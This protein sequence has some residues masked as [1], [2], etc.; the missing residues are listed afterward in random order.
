MSTRLSNWPTAFRCASLA[1]ACLLGTTL[2]VPIM[3]ANEPKPDAE[4]G[5]KAEF[6]PTKLWSIHLEIPAAE[7]AVMLPAPGV[8]FGGG[9][10][11]PPKPQSEKKDDKKRATEK[12][13][14]GTE[15]PW[16]EA[17]IAIDG[18]A[19][20]QVGVRYT[21]DM[22]Y[23]V[24]GGGLKRPL[25]IG[26]DTFG[27]EPFRGLSGV[28]LQAMPLDPSRARQVVASGVFRAAGVPTPR[29]AFAEVTLTVPGKHDKEYLGLFTVVEDVDAR[30]LTDN[31]DS[32]SGLLMRPFGGRGLDDLG[33]D[34]ER[35]KG[36]YR[37]QRDVTKNEAKRVIEFVHLV[38]KS[39]DDEFKNRIGEFLNV[40]PFLRFMA[41]NALTANLES[42]FALGHNYVLYLDPKT[43][44]FHFIPGDLEFSFANFLLMGTPDQL[45]EL[46]VLKPYPGANKLPDRLLAIKEVNER[47]RQLLQELTEKAFTKE[48]LVRD[49]E[50]IEK[51]TKDI[52]AK[53]AT[54]VAA[55]QEQPGFGGAGLGPQ[56][57]D[58]KMFADKRTASVATQLSG[59]S[60]GYAPQQ[61]GFGPPPPGGGFGNSGGLGP[62]QDVKAIDERAFAVEVKAPAGF[63]ATL[64]AG[65]PKVNSPVAIACESSGAIYVA[66]DEQGSLGRTPG[67][68]RIV[69][70]V[71]RDSDGKADAATTFAKV[72]HPRGVAYRDG[73]V[74][75]CHPPDLSVY[76]DTNGDGVADQHEVLVT[77]LTTNQITDRGGDHT[78]NGV[79][80]GI[81]G[82][83]YISTV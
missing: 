56:P 33:D 18:T 74:W 67:G 47:Y 82:W 54:A 32:E 19:L 75:V 55:R 52:R 7:F 30:F 13:L 65:P 81:D 37:P 46:S 24:S 17:T 70:L 53:E 76:R 8:G 15:F 61:F 22:T 14:F 31:F 41:A 27:R 63:E 73:N 36:V 25:K 20:N 43:N 50:V 5:E 58:L 80:L 26:F 10:G 51:T 6:G 28:Q 35:Y 68:G 34:W 62:P 48:K 69:R 29:T 40:E 66:V 45:M 1:L 57:P 49:A 12:N 4:T 44:K 60:K 3:S 71:D 38:N 83:L 79:R 77:G 2:P 78:T 64:F 59:K 23:F 72:E 21:G 16:V 39:S 9:F 42:F 11:P